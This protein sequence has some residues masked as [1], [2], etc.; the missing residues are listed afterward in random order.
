MNIAMIPD[1]EYRLFIRNFQQIKNKYFIEYK[2]NRNSI[3]FRNTEIFFVDPCFVICGDD[4]TILFRFHSSWI[5][6]I[7]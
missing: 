6:K 4:G 5:N 2:T 7:S 1:G 3:P